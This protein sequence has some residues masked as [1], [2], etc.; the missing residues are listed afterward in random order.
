MAVMADGD[1]NYWIRGQMD[2]VEPRQGLLILDSCCEVVVCWNYFLLG[3]GVVMSP[4]RRLI[5]FLRYV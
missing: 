5:S 4:G 1:T 3:I 2:R